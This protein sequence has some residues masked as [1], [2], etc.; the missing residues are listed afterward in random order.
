MKRIIYILIS[1]L[2]ILSGVLAFFNMDKIAN[3]TIEL[4]KPKQ[5]IILEESNNYTRNYDYDRF[6][7]DEDYIPSN[8][9]DLENMY[10]NILNNGWTNFTFYCPE[11]YIECINDVRSL[12]KDTVL[13][14][15]INNYVN[16]FNSFN[17]IDTTLDENA[18]ITLA[19]HKAY[20]ENEIEILSTSIDEIITNNIYVEDTDI[21]KIRKIKNYLVDNTIYDEDF[22]END[23]VSPSTKA[24]GALMHG[25]A[26]CSGYSDT[27]ALFL[28]RLNIP[29]LKV[30]SENHIW[31]LVYVDGSWKHLDVTWSD[32]D[33]SK[34][35]LKERFFLI[36]ASELLKLD[37]KEHSF[38]TIFY[39]EAS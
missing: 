25:K 29:N 38:D 2:L 26:V 34:D 39:I 5:K 30:S 18:G 6:N 19:I 32:T 21:Q 37:E 1:I 11:E 23:R 22:Q 9:E 13:V 7:Y 35:D 28:D 10:F 8:K 27:M 4:F 33:T 17:S 15:K 14:S 12:S 20:T 3:Y 16:P 31:N 36:T 24:I